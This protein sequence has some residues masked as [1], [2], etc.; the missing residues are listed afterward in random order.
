[1]FE[2]KAKDES[3]TAAIK[4]AERQW[5]RQKSGK[6]VSKII[7]GCQPG[8]IVIPYLPKWKTHKEPIWC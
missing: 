7:S 2:S 1:M 5:R 3:K 8:R 6:R 4:A